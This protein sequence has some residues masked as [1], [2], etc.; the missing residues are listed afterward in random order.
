MPLTKDDLKPGMLVKT[1]SGKLYKIHT[2]K[3]GGVQFETVNV[4]DA[5]G[6]YIVENG[7]YVTK[8]DFDRVV[9]TQWQVNEKYP[10]GRDYQASRTLKIKELSLP[11]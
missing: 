6:N 10:E 2:T 5:L 8:E 3:E 11:D 4:K 9:A 7:Y 1:K